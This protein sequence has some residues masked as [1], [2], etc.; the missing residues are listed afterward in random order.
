MKNREKFINLS[1]AVSDF[2]QLIFW[3]VATLMQIF[4]YENG[5]WNLLTED[6]NQRV[7][8][9]LKFNYKVAKSAYSSMT[10]S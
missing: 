1:G 8:P 9:V 3:K 7:D 4:G 10:L 5:D 6:A 2:V